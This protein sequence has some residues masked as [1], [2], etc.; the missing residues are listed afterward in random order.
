MKKTIVFIFLATSFFS[1]AQKVPQLEFFCTLTVKL[2]PPM[3]VGE[4]AHG[5][6]RIIPIIGGEVAGPGIKGE[7]IKGGADWQ[8]VR[9]DGVS[10]LEAH[11]QFKTDDGIIIYVKNVGLRAASPEIAAKIARGDQ[12]DASQYYFRA[13]PKFEAPQGKYSWINDVIFICTGERQRDAVILHV[14]KVE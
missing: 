1:Q 13:V 9:K 7:I 3:V 12:V 2:D 6:R 5:T 11:Y 8:V 10:E 4:T 14:W